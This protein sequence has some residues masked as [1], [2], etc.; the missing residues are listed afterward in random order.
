MINHEFFMKAAIN[1]AK[2]AEKRREVPVGAVIVKDN[3][4]IAKAYNRREIDKSSLSHAEILAI[5]KACKRLKAWRLMGCSL[6]VTLEPCPMCAGAIIQSRIE[7]VYF[8]AFDNR[9]GA[10]GSAIQLFD[11][12]RWNHKVAF[13]G[14]ILEEACSNM[15]KSFFRKLRNKL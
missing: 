5:K 1:E 3:K 2:K 7:N 4:I 13:E 9:F 10:C 6:Y 14:G 12:S 15:L 8:G 11:D